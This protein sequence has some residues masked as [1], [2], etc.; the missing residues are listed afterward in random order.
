MLEDLR[1]GRRFEVNGSRIRIGRGPNC[2]VRPPGVDQTLIS[3]THAEIYARSN[4]EAWVRDAHSVNGTFLN[5][6]WV[7]REQR[8][9]KRDQIAIG[10][11]GPVLWVERLSVSA[12]G[13]PAPGWRRW[14]D[15]ILPGRQQS[16][17]S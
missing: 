11:D 9:K 3:R 10:E 5:G 14:L 17:P 2:E 13:A 15:W 4:G 16:L 1:S 12:P 6:R 7:E 8:I